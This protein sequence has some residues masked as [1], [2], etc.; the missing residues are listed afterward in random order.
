MAVP[1]LGVAA[2][3]IARFAVMRMAAP[4]ARGL[5]S[6]GA[7]GITAARA[8]HASRAAAQ[9]AASAGARGAATGATAGA[10]TTGAATGA[11]AQ[12]AGGAAASG[13][14]GQAATRGS[15]FARNR[16]KTGAAGV[17]GGDVLLNDGDMT[18]GA[19]QM[20]GEAVARGGLNVVRNNIV[21]WIPAIIGAILGVFTGGGVFGLV[22]GGIGGFVGREYLREQDWYLQFE[23]TAYEFI[24]GEKLDRRSFAEKV[25]DTV[26]DIKDSTLSL[27]GLGSEKSAPDTA[28][29]SFGAATDQVT[30]DK[31]NAPANPSAGLGPRFRRDASGDASGESP[32]NSETAAGVDNLQLAAL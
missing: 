11:A 26:A 28:T 4:A 15:W 24:T 23:E 5:W 6:L 30:V 27:V 13:A 29:T 9:T 1:L 8:A 20:G 18:L 12:S 21:N 22:A 19:L 32:P 17:V 10:Q 14:A 16:I 7:R 2:W 25:G 31:G 3:G